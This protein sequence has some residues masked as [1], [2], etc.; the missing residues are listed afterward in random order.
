MHW[1]KAKDVQTRRCNRQISAPE[2]PNWMVPGTADPAFFSVVYL[3]KALPGQLSSQVHSEHFPAVGVCFGAFGSPDTSC[4][5]A[6]NALAMKHL[7]ICRGWHP[8]CQS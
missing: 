5:Y 7:V 2:M 6:P 1:G 4:H 8:N 3:D